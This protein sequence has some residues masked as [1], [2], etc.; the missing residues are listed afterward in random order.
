MTLILGIDP[1]GTGGHTGVV[2]LEH[3]RDNPPELVTSWAIPGDMDSFREWWMTSYDFEFEDVTVV[4]EMFVNRNKPG[5]DLTPM[6]FEGAVR[7]LVPDVVLQPAAGKNTAVPD[8]ALVNLG[9]SKDAF[10]GDHHGDRWEAL[11]H[12]IWYIR[13]QDH[14][15]TLRKGWPRDGGS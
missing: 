5:A 6:L 7:Y 2:L 13:K 12:V 11:R 8:R 10:K 1:G 4:C 14:V 3:T 15:P 9:F